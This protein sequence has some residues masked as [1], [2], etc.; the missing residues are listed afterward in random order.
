[1][2]DTGRRV[3]CFTDRSDNEGGVGKVVGLRTGRR[4]SEGDAAWRRDFEVGDGASVVLEGLFF[5][6]F[7]LV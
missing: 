6:A 2:G 4:V 7:E 5:L 3:D 1:M